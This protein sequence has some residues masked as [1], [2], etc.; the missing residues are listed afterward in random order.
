MKAGTKIFSLDFVLEA[1]SEN[2][3]LEVLEMV[4]TPALEAVKLK[5]DLDV[6]SLEDTCAAA[7]RAGYEICYADLPSQV[8]GLAAV[9]ADKPHIVVN[10]AKSPRHQQYTV[11]HELGHHVLHRNHLR[12]PD[13]P[14][15]PSKDVEEFQ[16]HMFATVLVLGVTRGNEQNDVLRQNPESSAVALKSLFATGFVIVV[17][18]VAHLVSRLIDNLLAGAVRKK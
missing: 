9:I 7:E 17:A 1:L 3:V 10:R 12:N 8:S 4:W 2:F 5:Q 16:A 6:R 14:V 11:F 18:L 15:L 13:Q